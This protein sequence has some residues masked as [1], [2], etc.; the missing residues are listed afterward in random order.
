MGSFFSFSNAVRRFSKTFLWVGDV[1]EVD[2]GTKR[3]VDMYD[4]VFDTVTRRGPVP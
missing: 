2:S 4:C 1:V 3:I